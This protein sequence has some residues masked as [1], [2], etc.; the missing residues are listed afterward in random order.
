ML[1]IIQKI[2]DGCISIKIESQR[3]DAFKETVI[4]KGGYPNQ[5]V[6]ITFEGD[7]VFSYSGN[8]HS[9]KQQRTTPIKERTEK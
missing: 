1:N 9:E 7:S 3:L 2:V 4:S 5:T 6:T 8:T